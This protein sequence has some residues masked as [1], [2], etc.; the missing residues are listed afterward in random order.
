METKQDVK[1]KK[2][3][4]EVAPATAQPVEEKKDVKETKKPEPVKKVKKTEAMVI[5]KSLQISKKH[6]MYI[7]RFIK[8]KTID[9]AI[10]DLE[11]VIVFKK[12]VP[13]KGE[14]PH[15]KGPGM[16]SGRY[17]IN[18]SK[19]F[20]QLLKGLKGNSIMNGMS[21]ENTKIV[22][23]SPSWDSRP[24]RSGGRKAKRVYILIKAK[25]DV[26]NG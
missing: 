4:K 13:F 20:I 24:M 9:A 2:E 25:E 19:V 16:M 22:Y 17:P 11:R 18:A 21:L 12:I 14:I 5:G 10:A 1:Q 6:A 26:K 23:A 7:S 3:T 8:F 15:R